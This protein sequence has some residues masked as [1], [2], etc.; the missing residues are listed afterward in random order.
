MCLGGVG[1]IGYK[2]PLGSFGPI[3]SRCICVFGCA[4][5][6]VLI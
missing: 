2:I 4:M 1:R 5:I 3:S 6:A